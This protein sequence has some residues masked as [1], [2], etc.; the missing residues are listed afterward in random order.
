MSN[1]KS[2]MTL[3]GA[4]ELRAALTALPQITEEKVVGVGLSR[5]AA[6]LRT[7]MK[8]AASKVSGMLRKSIGSRRVGKRKGNPKYV[9]GLTKNFYYKVLDAGRK[10]YTKADGTQV[11]GTPNFKSNGT[12]IEQTWNAKKE[13]IANLVVEESTKAFA[14]EAGKLYA[15][16]GGRTL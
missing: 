3:K 14:R 11:A 9:V 8:R 10:A 4:A 15:K 6:R 2:T 13:E 1:G 16:S 12:Q 5:A 7:Y